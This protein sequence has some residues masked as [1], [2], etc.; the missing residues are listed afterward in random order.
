MI[1]IKKEIDTSGTVTISIDY[2]D[3]LRQKAG[4][5]DCVRRELD[6]IVR[7]S[8]DERNEIL[9]RTG[10]MEDDAPDEEYDRMMEE[11]DR[12]T[13][14]WVNKGWLKELLRNHCTKKNDGYAIGE[15]ENDE[16]ERLTVAWE[17]E[18]E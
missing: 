1:E 6:N 12:A 3:Q 15:A 8:T 18:Y 4:E 2:F 5:M 9:K 11:A 14:I 16:L 17:E 13:I 7:I 10:W